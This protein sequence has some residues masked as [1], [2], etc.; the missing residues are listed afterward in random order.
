MIETLSLFRPLNQKLISLLGS[1][2]K[3]DWDKK[4]VAG[5]W[6]VKDVA[7]HLLDTNIRFISIYRDG[8]E[9]KPDVE[10]TSYRTLVDYLNRLN[11]DWV[12]AMK[13]VSAEQLVEMLALTHNDYVISLEKLDPD[14]P[15]KFSVA[16]AGEDVSPNWFHIA[17]DF[18][19]KW[20]H[21]QQIR[22]AVG[23]QGI[24]TKEFYK[25]VLRTFMRALPYKYKDTL[26]ADGT[27]IQ[28]TIDSEA[29]GTW[30]LEMKDNQ[31]SVS[32]KKNS[33]ANVKIVVPVDLSWRLFTKAVAYKDVKESISIEG[34]ER[35]ALPALEMI[36][37]IA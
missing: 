35:L 1:L 24:L 14:A 11:A 10:I 27:C 7:A 25:P 23:Q 8:E 17:R 19:E 32:E 6:T 15:A 36:T 21:Q 31:W 16:W 2:S 4:T 29:G 13:R 18:T 30:W 3:E 5:S 33:I 26:A 22:D 9:L 34:E 28:L 20:H 37:V 12:K